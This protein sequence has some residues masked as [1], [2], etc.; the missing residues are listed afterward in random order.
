MLQLAQHRESFAGKQGYSP[1]LVALVG[2]PQ[3]TSEDE[4]MEDEDEPIRYRK[5]KP[6]RDAAASWFIRMLEDMQRRA[7]TGIRFAKHEKRVE[8]PSDVPMIDV[9]L[10]GDPSPGDGVPLDFWDPVHFNELPPFERARWRNSPVAL[11][12]IK[13]LQTDA[14]SGDWKTMS[15]SAFLS[16]YGD[17]KRALYVF[18]TPEEMRQMKA[19][20]H[21]PMADIGKRKTKRKK[22]ARGEDD[23]GE[24]AAKERV[25]NFCNAMFESWKNEELQDAPSAPSP[26]HD[27]QPQNS[28]SSSTATGTP[29][30]PQPPPATAHS[31]KPAGAPSF[32]S[33]HP[34]SQPPKASSSSQAGATPKSQPAPP[35][36][37][38]SFK[39]AGA[40]GI[41]T[42]PPKSQPPPKAPPKA[43]PASSSSPAGT[44][45]KPHPPPKASPATS[46]SP[47]GPSNVPEPSQEPRGPSVPPNAPRPLFV[48]YT[49]PPTEKLRFVYMCANCRRVPEQKGV[50]KTC[51][52]SSKSMAIAYSF[53]N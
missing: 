8:W 29:N 53:P 7:R 25:H 12:T 6:N 5:P 26:P 24:L 14:A 44:T 41:T 50:L 39:P 27:E 2:S 38:P 15:P 42:N 1:E 46:S 33:K 21:D 36:K 19:N 17:E 30:A 28:P 18:P 34:K 52:F 4:R 48:G 11:P 51:K 47:M 16:K 22:P 13:R 35:P 37:V 43:P 20:G 40:P 49:L 31:F 9:R 23:D 32:T 10:S 3:A 45:P